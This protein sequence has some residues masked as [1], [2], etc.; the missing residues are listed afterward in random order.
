MRNTAV[1][2][3]GKSAVVDAYIA[4]DIPAWSIWNGPQQ[5]IFKYDGD[6]LTTGE[7]LL[8]QAIEKLRRS[9]SE[10]ALTLKVYSD[11][12][13]G[14]KSNTPFDN[15]FTFSLYDPTEGGSPYQQN[16]TAVQQELDDMREEIRQLKAE[17]VEEEEPEKK[18]AV[19]AIMGVIEK[20][21]AEPEI[22]Q[23]VMGF[24][25]SKIR[26]FVNPFKPQPVATMGAV[27]TP[28]ASA[29]DT[30]SED[31]KT[32]LNQAVEILMQCDKE[33]GDHLLGLAMIAKNDPGKYQMALKFL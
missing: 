17:P 26:S 18:G 22:R 28:Q 7:D 2:F 13:G 30:L 5:L 10:A 8:K 20:M 23:A 4:N 25:V 1:L 29:W 12:K 19:G 15:S 6:D 9:G 24:V 16:R 3:R 27:D 31:Q 14:I 21:L 11:I 32:K 33:I